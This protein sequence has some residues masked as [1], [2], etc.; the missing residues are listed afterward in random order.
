MGEFNPLREGEGTLSAS[1]FL[2]LPMGEDHVILGTYILFCRLQCDG[3]A[4]CYWLGTPFTE[5]GVVVPQ[6]G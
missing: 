4:D 3:H 1:W 2:D 6:P 5:K